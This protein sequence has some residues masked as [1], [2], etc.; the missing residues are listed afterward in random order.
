MTKLKIEN[1]YVLGLFDKPSSFT[2]INLKGPLSRDSRFKIYFRLEYWGNRGSRQ[3]F[4][5][6]PFSKDCILI[7]PDHFVSYNSMTTCL[8]KE[9]TI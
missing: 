6:I 7:N 5:K 4:H 8:F 3:N 1:T 9:Q 2:K